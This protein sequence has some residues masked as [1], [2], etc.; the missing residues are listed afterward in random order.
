MARL[1]AVFAHLNF[2]FLLF[3]AWDASQEKNAQ[4][5]TELGEY[6]HVPERKT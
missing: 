2:S 6:P 5:E 4:N 3:S 1:K